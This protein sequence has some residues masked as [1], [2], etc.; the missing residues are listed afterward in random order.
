MPFFSNSIIQG[1]IHSHSTYVLKQ[2]LTN[3]EI[4]IVNDGST[5]TSEE[6]V[7]KFNDSN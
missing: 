6:I 7:L 3:F 2:I 5:D 4:I 1:K